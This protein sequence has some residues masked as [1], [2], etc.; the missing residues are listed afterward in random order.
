MINI[1]KS[2]EPDIDQIER[3]YD[4]ILDEEEAGNVMIGWVRGVYPTRNTAESQGV[5]QGICCVL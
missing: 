2:R 5:W 3:I 1:R 4:R